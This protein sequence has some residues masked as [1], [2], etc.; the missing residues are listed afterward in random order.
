MDRYIT[1]YGNYS[2][3]QLSIDGLRELAKFVVTE[4][5]KHHVGSIDS[6]LCFSEIESIYQEEMHYFDDSWIFVA[7]SMKNEILGAIRVM[8]WNRKDILPIEKLFGIHDLSSI[9]Q[10]DCNCHIW[11]VGRL[12][13]SSTTD[14]YGISLFK[15]LM[16]YAISPICK[17]EN[18]IMFAECDRKLLR[19]L[20]RL[21]INTTILGP[22]IKYLGSETIPIYTTRN[23]LT[24]FLIKNFSLALNIE[25]KKSSHCKYEE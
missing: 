19:A 1:S 22:G 8:E 13:V 24:G 20:N 10:K 16:L 14:E 25:Y 15:I 2:I 11:H 6:V 17:Y 23:E 12:A 9:S 21:G 4:N 18:G 5:Y 7:K 3:W